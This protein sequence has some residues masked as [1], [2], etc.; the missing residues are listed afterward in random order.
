MLGIHL[1]K[2]LCHDFAPFCKHPMCGL[3]IINKIGINT[4]KNLKEG[5][6]RIQLFGKQN[7]WGWEYN[8]LYTW[9]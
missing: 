5:N 1:Q 4:L 7:P 9:V 6:T 8:T 3:K 2:D